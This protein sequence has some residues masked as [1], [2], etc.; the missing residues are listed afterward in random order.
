MSEQERKVMQ[1]LDVVQ[2]KTVPLIDDFPDLALL[3]ENILLCPGYHWGLR[4]SSTKKAREWYTVLLWYLEQCH[5]IFY[6]VLP[7]SRDHD[8]HCA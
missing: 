3:A 8:R 4:H 6:P 2:G 5:K 1:A 7:V